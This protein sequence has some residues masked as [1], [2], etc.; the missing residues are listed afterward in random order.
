MSRLL[1]CPYLC[2]C[3]RLAREQR[4]P[5]AQVLGSRCL[6]TPPPVLEGLLWSGVPELAARGWGVL[7]WDGMGGVSQ[8]GEKGS[9]L[10]A[11]GCVR[12]KLRFRPV[13]PG[14]K[15]HKKLTLGL[16]SKYRKTVKVKE[17]VMVKDPERDF[18]E[19]EKVRPSPPGRQ[20]RHVKHH[21]EG[22]QCPETS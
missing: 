3:V 8:V 7:G 19:K 9:A 11:Q 2:A 14:S 22:E 4:G 18:H 13:D 17:M 15:I 20:T 10:Q 21:P 12:E 6:M 5:G 16:D 1:L